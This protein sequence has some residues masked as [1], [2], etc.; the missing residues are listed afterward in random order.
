MVIKREWY[1][2]KNKHAHQWNKIENL[3]IKPYVYS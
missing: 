2:Q 1:W 3:D